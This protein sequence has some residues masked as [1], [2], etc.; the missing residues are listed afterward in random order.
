MEDFVAEGDL[1]CVSLALEVSEEK[2][3]NLWSRVVTLRQDPT[4]LS[5]G[6]GMVVQVFNPRRQS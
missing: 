4:Q 3:F 2:N 5:L 1:N 6:P